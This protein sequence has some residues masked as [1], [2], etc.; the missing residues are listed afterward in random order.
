M[1][2]KKKEPDFVKQ[3]SE[4]RFKMQSAYKNLSYSDNPVLT[5]ALIYEIKSLEKKHEYLLGEIKQEE[6]EK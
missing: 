6:Q 4:I 3:I 5:E 1:L 2:L